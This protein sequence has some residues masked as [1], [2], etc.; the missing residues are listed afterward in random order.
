MLQL[1]QESGIELGRAGTDDLR[2]AADAQVAVEL[3]VAVGSALLWVRR[4]VFDALDRP[5]QLLPAS[6]GPIL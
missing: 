1:L 3:K 5:V 6:I 2:L 4:L